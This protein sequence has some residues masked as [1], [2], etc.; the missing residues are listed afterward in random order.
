MDGQPYD[1]HVWEFGAL[2][3]LRPAL[4]LD[5]VGNRLNSEPVRAACVKVDR[6]IAANNLASQMAASVEHF[7]RGLANNMVVAST[8]AGGESYH[9][10]GD[11]MANA[12][13]P[14]CVW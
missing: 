9:L 12:V 8:P 6:L 3:L 5:E 14:W 7:V 13:A 10:S 1:K 4:G 11:T 2:A